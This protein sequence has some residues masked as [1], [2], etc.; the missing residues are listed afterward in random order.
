MSRTTRYTIPRPIPLPW[1]FDRRGNLVKPRW[2]RSE[3][4]ASQMCD[5]LRAAHPCRSCKA[6]GVWGG[7]KDVWWIGDCRDCLGAGIEWGDIPSEQRG[8]RE[9]TQ[10]L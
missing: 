8:D 7:G 1:G 3:R 5:R 2:L 6:T 4:Y 9:W 10:Y